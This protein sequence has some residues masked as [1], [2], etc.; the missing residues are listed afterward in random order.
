MLS[1]YVVD[2]YYCR[3]KVIV[4]EEAG[5]RELYKLVRKLQLL[6]RQSKTSFLY[7]IEDKWFLIK[8]IRECKLMISC[9]DF[10]GRITPL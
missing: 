1:I 10:I 3:N 2:I 5:R 9:E 4:G 6:L 8:F 7:V